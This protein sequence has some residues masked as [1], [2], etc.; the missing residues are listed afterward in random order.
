MI[1][2]KA[3]GT[4]QGANLLKGGWPTL[5]M[6]LSEMPVHLR[7]AHDEETGLALISAYREVGGMAIMPGII[8]CKS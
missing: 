7:P 6:I 3:D 4:A 2:G 8:C 1:M 5:K